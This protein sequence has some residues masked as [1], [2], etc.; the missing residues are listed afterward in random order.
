MHNP[1]EGSQLFKALEVYNECPRAF[2][3]FID[4]KVGVCIY[5]PIHLKYKHCYQ[6][7]DKFSYKTALNLKWK[8]YMSVSSR[9]GD[10]SILVDIVT[11]TLYFKKDLLDTCTMVQQIGMQSLNFFGSLYLKTKEIENNLEAGNISLSSYEELILQR[12][13][14]G[15]EKSKEL[16]Q[17]C[18]G[19]W[20]KFCSIEDMKKLKDIKGVGS[21]FLK[22]QLSGSM[23]NVRIEW[24][25]TAGPIY[26]KN[27]QNDFYS[28]F[29]FSKKQLV[30]KKSDD[31]KLK[32]IA[33]WFLAFQANEIKYSDRLKQEIKGYWNSMKDNNLIIKKIEALIADPTKS[34]NIGYDLK[35]F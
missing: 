3:H 1:L 12:E 29:S 16:F 11:K 33:A 14:L 32:D 8:D 26:C 30:K 28:C 20:S 23:D 22:R 13:H 25:K 17:E 27:K 7:S 5:D 19:S 15:Y 6:L 2:D 10:I 35:G 21:L 31:E 24:L 34:H 18:S 4:N 9:L